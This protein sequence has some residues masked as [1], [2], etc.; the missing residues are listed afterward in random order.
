MLYITSAV[1]LAF[2]V[3]VGSITPSTISPIG[4]RLIPVQESHPDS[5]MHMW[6]PYT[7]YFVGDRHFDSLQR[8][9]PR[10]ENITEFYLYAQSYL[11]MV[12]YNFWER[13]GGC[14]VKMKVLG[15]RVLTILEEESH[16]P[17]CLE[18]GEILIDLQNVTLK[19]FLA[20]NPEVN[21]ADIVVFLTGYRSKTLA[22]WDESFVYSPDGSRIC[23][24][25]KYILLTDQ[26]FSYAGQE[27]L[28]RKLRSKMGVA[29]DR[30]S[31]NICYRIR[32]AYRQSLSGNEDS[33]GEPILCYNT[34]DTCCL[35]HFYGIYNLRREPLCKRYNT[36]EAI[37]FTDRPDAGPGFMCMFS[38]VFQGGHNL[39]VAPVGTVVR[40]T[41]EYWSRSL[42]C[43]SDEDEICNADGLRQY[44]RLYKDFKRAV[45]Y[46]WE[47]DDYEVPE[48][49]TSFCMQ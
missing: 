8:V 2:V 12:V 25:D 34:I 29:E 13:H 39:A 5:T 16:L 27:D 32:N 30:P 20:R 24:Q 41:S 46:A 19:E 11:N 36:R 45:L 33:D 18:D 10:S 47:L 21:A 44:H 35:P 6:R 4:A 28:F 49:D 17:K 22:F 48:T 15:T 23:T 42:L 26:P 43:P 7:V 31:W 1:F 37:D 38:C 14:A 3:L 40:A 9:V